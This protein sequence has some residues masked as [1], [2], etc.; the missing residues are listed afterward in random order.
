MIAVDQPSSRGM[1][2][3]RADDHV[4]DM[5]RDLAECYGVKYVR[6]AEVVEVRCGDCC[7]YDDTNGPSSG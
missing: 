1:K 6:G 7:V 3:P 5:S 4:V 2:A